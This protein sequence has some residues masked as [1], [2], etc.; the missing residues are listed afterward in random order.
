MEEDLKRVIGSAFGVSGFEYSVFWNG[1]IVAQKQVFQIWCK[2]EILGYCKISNQKEIYNRFLREFDYLTWLKSC[3]VENI[4]V[5]L[6]VGCMNGSY[7]FLQSTNKTNKFKCESNLGDKQIDFITKF[8]NLTKINCN[9]YDTDFVKSLQ[10]LLSLESVFSKYDY[11]LFVDLIKKIE[12]YFTKNGSCVDFAAYHADFTPWNTY[13][14]EGQLFAFDFEYS[15]KTY[16][17]YLDLF[18]FF[19]QVALLE[20]KK[21][22]DEVYDYYLENKKILLKFID[23]DF[24]YI[25]VCYLL[26]VISFYFK[27]SDGRFD[28]ADK[29]YCVW[30]GLLNKLN[31]KIS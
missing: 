30:I 7:L 15:K 31:N 25:Y 9:Y 16:P 27:I 26:D 20:K 14:Q 2:N 10:Y 8:N 6:Y 29:S 22:L 21:K 12:R 13:I 5:A 4:P 24:D 23:I 11:D 17:L 28:T 18:H 19:T 3:N 1:G